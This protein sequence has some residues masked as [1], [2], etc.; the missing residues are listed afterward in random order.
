[1]CLISQKHLD[2]TLLALNIIADGYNLR[3]LFPNFYNYAVLGA[4]TGVILTVLITI[5]FGRHFDNKFTSIGKLPR[6]SIKYAIIAGIAGS[7][8]TLLYIYFLQKYDPSFIAATIPLTLVFLMVRDSISSREKLTLIEITSI[9]M[10]CIGA[11]LVS[12]NGGKFDIIALLL[13]GVLLNI[14]NALY[15]HFMKIGMNSG[16]DAFNF[17]LLITLVL[18]VAFTFYSY[19]HLDFSSVKLSSILYVTGSMLFAF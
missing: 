12:F 5:L 15:S 11:I 8:Y 13:A 4:W 6:K 16:A 10:V 9:I 7:I 2:Y 19:P 1:M 3:V 14:I 18:A 17:R